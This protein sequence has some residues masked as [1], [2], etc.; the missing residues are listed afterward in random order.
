MTSRQFVT[1]DT[2]TMPWEERFNEW[3]GRT[4][5]RKILFADPE[6]GVMIAL[7]RY[8]AGVLNPGHTHPCGHGMYV[9]EGQLITHRGVYGPGIFV[10]FPEGEVMEHGAS[11]EG[12]V[13]ALFVTN[14]TFRIDYVGV[15]AAGGQPL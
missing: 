12:D 14:K 4:L 13:V 9:L 15:P 8:P 3:V 6:T 5:Y 10:W 1:V 11:S 2:A 7:V